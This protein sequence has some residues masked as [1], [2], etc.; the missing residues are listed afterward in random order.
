MPGAPPQSAEF[1]GYAALRVEVEVLNI[2]GCKQRFGG[3]LLELT[4]GVAVMRRICGALFLAFLIPV[5][6]AVFTKV[7]NADDVPLS[8]AVQ[9][10]IKPEG[11]TLTVLLRVPMDAL[12]EVD[13]PTRGV[14]GSLIFSEADSTLETATNVYILN[15][16]QLFEDD[17]VLEEK[18]LARVRVSL[19]SDRSF[20]SYDQAVRNVN[21]DRLDDSVDL[22]WRQGMLDVLVTYPIRS[23]ESRFSVDAR[24]AGLGVETNTVLRFVLPSGAERPFS[25]VG[26]PGLVYLD[27]SWFQASWRFVELGF[28]HILAGMDHLLFLLCLLIPIRSVRAL[29]PVITSFTIAHSITLIASVFGV[30]PSVLWFPPLIETLIALSIVYMAFE[31][32]VGFKQENR[33][34]VTFGFGLIHGFGFSFLLTESMQFAGTHLITALLSFNVGVEFGQLLVL[35]LVVP[36]L[37]ILFKYVVAEKVGIILLSAL[38]AHTAWHWM[39]ERWNALMDYDIRMP[40]MNSDFYAGLWLWGMLI[41]VAAAVL[42]IMNILFSKYFATSLPVSAEEI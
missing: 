23:S 15:A 42:W 36:L 7:S 3:F 27:P 6:F 17:Q 31:N 4:N 35:V 8:V 37:R 32:I 30:L 13:F 33:W 10:Y 11:N 16:L 5:L 2:N 9:A 25:F 39:A 22:Y 1:S 34:L 20:N 40:I 14:P 38:V 19:P 24:F 41:I 29:V 21:K 18:S 26:N 12:G 28:K